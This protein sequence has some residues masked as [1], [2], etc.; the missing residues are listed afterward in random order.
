MKRLNV[1]LALWLVGIAVFSVVGVHFLHGYQVDRNANSLKVQ[2]DQA[3]TAGNDEEAVKLYSQYLRHRDDRDAYEALAE[4]TV[5]VAKNPKATRNDFFKAYNVLEEA[6]RRYPDL[7][8][9]RMSLIDY[10]IAMR[11]ITDAQD[12]LRSLKELGSTDTRIPLKEAV[13][14]ALNGEPE[15]ARVELYKMVG[16]DPETKQ[17]AAE[18]PV[19]AKEVE[20]FS[21]LANLLQGPD[22]DPALA[23]AVMEKLVEWNPD[24][25]KAHLARATHLS[26]LWQKVRPDT[27]EGKDLQAS[28]F[29]EIQEE[30]KKT[31]AIEPDNVDAMLL[32]AATAMVKQ[33]YKT[34]QDLLD[35]AVKLQPARADVYLRRSLLA[36]VQKQPEKAA[37]ELKAGIKAADNTRP[38]LEQLVELQFLLRDLDAVSE[39][40]EQM[41]KVPGIPAETIGFHEARVLFGREKFLE[42]TRAFERVRPAY[43][44]QGAAQLNAVNTLLGR[45]YARLGMSDR[46]LEVNRRLLASFPTSIEARIGEA[47]ALQAL[48]RFD[49]AE[50]SVTLLASAAKAAGPM[51]GEILQLVVNQELNK[52]LAERNWERTQELYKLVES[53]GQRTALQNRL[54]QVNLLLAQGKSDEALGILGALRKENPKD[55][56]VWLLLCKLMS[57]EEKYRDRLPQL[58]NLAEKELG[59]SAPL[60]IERIKLIMRE[61]GE[62][63]SKQLQELEAGIKQFEPAQQLA[64]TA[65]LGTA[66]LMV[67][68]YD[69]GKRCLK[70]VM[71]G[72]PSNVRIR[73]VLLELALERKD[74]VTVNEIM[75][76]L[77]SSPMF[78]PQSTLYRYAQA[79]RQVQQLIAA[80]A[81]KATPLTEDEHRIL[82]EA[83]KLVD[84]A[85]ALRAEWA[86]LWRLRSDINQLE[87]NLNGAISD[88]QQSLTYSQT[89]QEVAAR[90]LVTYL[91]AA[92]RFTEANEAM[93]YL[94][95]HELPEAMRRI[96]EATKVRGGDPKEAIAMVRKDIEKDPENPSN[97]LWLGEMLEATGDGAGAEQAFRQATEK[98]PKLA[99]AWEFLVRRLMANNKPE[100]AATA[101]EQAVKN[102]G[103]EPLAIARLYQRIGK[104][105]LAE[106]AYQQ[107]LAQKPG[108]L[109]VMRHLAEFYV[110]QK[111]LA[112]SQQQLDELIAAAGKSDDPSAKMHLAWART[113]KAQ[114]MAPDR[115]YAGTL[116]AIKLIEQ[117]A[118]NGELSRPDTLA[119]L[120]L[121]STQFEEPLSRQK[122]IK[123]YEKLRAQQTLDD[124][125]AIALAQLYNRENDWQAARTLMSEVTTKFE[126]SPEVAVIFAGMLF[127]H[128]EFDVARQYVDRAES[129]LQNTLAP[130]TAAAARGAR[131]LRA[132]LLA[133]D[134]KQAEAAKLLEGW[135]PRPLPQNQLPLLLDVAD[136]MEQ[137]ELY[138]DAERLL[139]EYLGQSPDSGKLALAAYLGR[140]GDIEQSFTLL[141]E[142]GPEVPVLEVISV[143]KA[144]LRN[145]PEKVTDAQKEQIQ[146]W[147]QKALQDSADSDQT[148]LVVAEAYDLLGRYDEVERIYREMLASPKLSR[149]IRAVVQNNLAF[150]LA[151][152]KPT[153]A[154]G[155]EALKLIEDAIQVL[156]PTS[157]V[158]DTRA[159]AYMAQGKYDQAAADV[160]L[161]AGD[162]PTT[163]KYYHLAQVE[164]QLGNVDA[165]REAIA[166]AQELHGEH[167]PFTPFERKGYEQLKSE[168]N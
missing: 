3:R 96:V 15:K 46:Q 155:A 122:A 152:A 50:A 23:D 9:V 156:G 67:N 110:L 85:I 79:A 159:L 108:D 83:R 29:A 28:L 39:T 11:R 154:R 165:A 40:C 127:E 78:G 56:S 124:Q 42:A 125:Q 86:P 136:Q 30:L 54:M 97:Y 144:N 10:T 21:A 146:S 14:F 137:L 17:F 115:D 63:T 84:E 162:R 35:R 55:V 123:L 47:S 119:I 6:I 22:G 77:Q 19:T 163:S 103:D 104:I 41:S 8:N 34:S 93:K 36:Q 26:Q 140:R 128:D 27:P 90:K 52:P 106:K 1:K 118:Q 145:Y 32:S 88:L 53:S 135:L 91:Y 147:C 116:E 49:E 61:P 112:K 133:R 33:D 45:A 95:D 66:Y 158:I 31:T 138:Q 81:G 164:K 101:T 120:S 102:L 20:A 38:L 141:S 25:A 143:G 44:R 113:Q 48:G 131:I 4:L 134:G 2:A 12:H 16:Y 76:E 70:T 109:L 121:L 24:L 126:N 107:A 98:G 166:K 82:A 94:G 71:Q 139:R 100:D 68:D 60:V 157:D 92:G 64:I 150:V 7:H 5:E 153:P 73:Q 149:Y 117:N 105:D 37:E 62:N 80:R 13:C 111:D 129:L 151:G 168:M 51:Q 130:P 75:D 69:N 167:N 142:A 87:G 18:P 65:Q 89:G 74:E 132:R 57:S 160:R 161:A 72:E 58:L 114:G 148:R 99:R 59:P 43:E